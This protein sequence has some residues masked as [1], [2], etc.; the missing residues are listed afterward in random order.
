MTTQ[1][2]RIVAADESE[3]HTEPHIRGSRLTVRFVRKLVEEE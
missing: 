3:I 1:E 2:P